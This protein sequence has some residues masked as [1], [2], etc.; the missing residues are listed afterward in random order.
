MRVT[1]QTAMRWIV[2][3]SFGLWM[4]YPLT[5]VY[6]QVQST[7]HVIPQLKGVDVILESS[8]PQCDCEGH[9]HAPWNPNTRGLPSVFPSARARAK[10]AF[11]R[12]ISAGLEGLSRRIFFHTHTFNDDR[13]HLIVSPERIIQFKN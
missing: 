8:E 3:L 5:P 11:V 2:V 7:F 12:L 4:Q 9:P 1:S 13:D 10:S 6:S